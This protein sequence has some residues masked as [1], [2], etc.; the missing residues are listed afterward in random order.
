[1][2][3]HRKLKIYQY[4]LECA[5]SAAEWNPALSIANRRYLSVFSASSVPCSASSRSFPLRPGKTHFFLLDLKCPQ[6]FSD[7]SLAELQQPQLP[8]DPFSVAW[9]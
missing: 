3:T 4:A 6:L 1:M 2:F 7:F 9:V 5:G 8:A